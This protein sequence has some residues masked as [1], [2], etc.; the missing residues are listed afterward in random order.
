[1][2]PST[3]VSAGAAEIGHLRI[4]TTDITGRPHCCILEEAASGWGLGE[5]AQT[6][7][8]S[9]SDR[10]SKLWALADQQLDRVTGK[11]VGQAAAEGDAFAQ[12]VLQRGIDALAD[13]I[14]QM[15]T[16]V[17]APDR[18]WRRCLRFWEKNFCL[19]PC[20]PR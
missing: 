1:M 14:S 2:E 16:L 12:V 15:L 17:A 4:N 19:R 9:G 20:A 7:L 13:A 11:L 8:A 3:G 5:F 6:R 10:D 18:D